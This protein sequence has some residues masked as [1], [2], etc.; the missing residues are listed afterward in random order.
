M[1]PA[2]A[3]VPPVPLAG[4]YFFVPSQTVAGGLP[5][6]V[7]FKE[8]FDQYPVDSG[9]AV[10]TNGWIQN[11]NDASRT[12]AATAL[13]VTSAS[14][15]HFS[16]NC[17]CLDT[18]GAALYN[19]TTCHIQNVWIDMSVLMTPCEELPREDM[20]SGH[21]LGLCL[22]ADSR[23]NVYCGLTNGFIASDIQFA[24][25]PGQPARITLQI[26]YADNL[27]VPFFRISIDQTNVMWNAGYR[28]PEIPSASGGAWLPCATTNRTFNGLGLVGAGYVD[29]LSFGDTFPGSGGQPQVDI[30]QAVS[31]SW[32]SDYGRRYQVETCEDLVNG[33]WRSFGTPILGD[34]AT[35]TVFDTVG[36]T[37]RKFYRVTP[38][39]ESDIGSPSRLDLR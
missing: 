4:N 16:G 2:Y 21:Q 29:N 5:N 3:G 8:T 38:L 25:A 37:V 31:I 10:S 18:E 26:A 39:Q 23:L 6:A 15:S 32:L 34:G 11:I 9:F 35:N 14:P 1:A 22:D 19:S 24:S 33:E 17:L 7:P 12:V 28:L 36:S 20:T 30:T 13:P 27:T